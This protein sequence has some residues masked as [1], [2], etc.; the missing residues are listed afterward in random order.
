MRL[1]HSQLLLRMLNNQ[2]MLAISSSPTLLSLPHTLHPRRAIP[3]RVLTR[4][5]RS[6][7]AHPLNLFPPS[8]RRALRD[9]EVLPTKFSSH[10]HF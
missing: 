4:T 7:M 8:L 2:A 6:S 5:V 1:T 9:T 10:S 3:S